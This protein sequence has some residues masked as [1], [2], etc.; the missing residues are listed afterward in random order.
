VKPFGDII[1]QPDLH[2]NN[3][4]SILRSPVNGL[5]FASVSG[6]VEQVMLIV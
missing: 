2:S 1:N 3:R 6:P 5:T 4:L